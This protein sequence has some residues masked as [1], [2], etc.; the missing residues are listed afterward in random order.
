MSECGSGPSVRPTAGLAFHDIEG[1]EHV[2]NGALVRSA[3]AGMALHDLECSLLESNG[4]LVQ[5]D[6][7]SRLQLQ[8][9]LDDC[10]F[11]RVSTVGV[12]LEHATAGVS[13]GIIGLL[14]RSVSQS[15][16]LSSVISSM[17]VAW[18][19]LLLLL[20]FAH[21]VVNLLLVLLVLCTRV[22]LCYPCMM[23]MH[24]IRGR[25]RLAHSV[26]GGGRGA[27][28]GKQSGR[29]FLHCPRGGG[30]GKFS[31][32]RRCTEA[33][34]RFTSWTAT[35]H[36]TRQARGGVVT[37]S[38]HPEVPDT[39]FASPGRGLG[40]RQSMGWTKVCNTARSGIWVLKGNARTCM[41][42]ENL[43][44]LRVGWISR[45]SY[46]T[47]WVTPRH[48]S[49]C[50]YQCGH[51]AVVRPQTNDASGMGFLVCGAGSHPSCHPGVQ[52]GM[53]QLK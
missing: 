21:L 18:L 32:G 4:A 46:E 49:L 40:I 27:K 20:L 5:R 26:P 38:L 2:S 15:S 31:A 45:G 50:S 10:R 47:A 9:G 30:R 3:L 16:L 14:E 35:R 22:A 1:S 48:D 23:H 34:C 53:C 8:D 52:E 24:I 33:G 19:L 17:G 36:G 29:R 44:H 6:C 7:V 13:T 25:T 41:L 12:D 42:P 11:R 51:G 37:P 43:H 28:R 39:R